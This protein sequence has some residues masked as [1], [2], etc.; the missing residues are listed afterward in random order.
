MLTK[1]GYETIG[2]IAVICFV[3]IVSAMLINSNYIRYGMISFSIVMM[4]FTLNFF[5]DPERITPQ[6]KDILISPADGKV[7][8][9]K[10]VICDK[11]VNGEAWQ[12]SIFMSPLNVHVNR[13]PVSGTVEYLNYIKGKFLVAYD[14]KADKD[15]ERMEIGINSPEFGK[16]LF[17]QVSG[18]VARR[19]VTDLKIGQK[20]IAG[21]RF[22][23]IKFGS[24][25]DIIVPL[26][27]KPVVKEGDKTIA[28][29]SI[30]YEINK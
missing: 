17:T 18:F 26:K 16:I 10:K 12:I 29:E 3:I 30:I 24:R 11:Y 27:W 2:V 19:I 8:L 1:Y 28:G 4:V 13:I 14:D 15:N 7:M 6:I 5:R 20:V 23:M 22:G 21:E 25:V 9:I